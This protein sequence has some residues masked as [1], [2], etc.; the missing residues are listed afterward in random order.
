MVRLVGCVGDDYRPG[1]LLGVWGR[2]GLE[3]GGGGCCNLDVGVGVSVLWGLECVV[4]CG[5]LS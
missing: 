1:G 5:G 3:A 2:C 4:D